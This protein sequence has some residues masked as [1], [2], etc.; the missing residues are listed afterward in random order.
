MGGFRFRVS[1]AS[2]MSWSPLA[3]HGLPAT[4]A[5][6][7]VDPVSGRLFLAGGSAG[8]FHSDDGGAHWAHMNGDPAATSLAITVGRLFVVGGGGLYLGAIPTESVTQRQ[9]GGPAPRALLT[10]ALGLEPDVA[11]AI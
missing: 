4:G 10:C 11:T 2:G 3:G 8:L 7:A 5:G 9:I 6:L 1:T